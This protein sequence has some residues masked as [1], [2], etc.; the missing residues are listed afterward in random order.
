MTATVEIKT[1]RQTV[2]RYLTKPITKTL[3]ESLR[4]R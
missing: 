3:N 4:E 2:L 1:G